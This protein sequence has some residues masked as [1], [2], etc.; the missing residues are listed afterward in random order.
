M[1]PCSQEFGFTFNLFSSGISQFEALTSLSCPKEFKGNVCTGDEVVSISPPGFQ[2]RIVRQCLIT[3]QQVKI[4][5]VTCRC[6]FISII[7]T[8]A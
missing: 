7:G 4:A 8:T 5:L 3:F 6:S 2:I 1:A